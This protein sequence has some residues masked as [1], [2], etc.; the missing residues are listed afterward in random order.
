[1]NS[2]KRQG[3]LILLG[4]LAGVA[5]LALFVATV[6]LWAANQRGAAPDYLG[7]NLEAPWFDGKP[8]PWFLDMFDQPSVKPQESGT[9]QRFPT[10]SVPRSGVEPTIPATAMVEGRLQR[11]VEP[12]NP[13]E[14]TEAS[15]ANGRENYQRFCAACHGADGLADTPVVQLGMPAP[16]IDRLVGLLSE[17]HLYNKIRY[18]G[19]I[20]PGYG[21]QTTQQE[22]WD[23]VNYLKSEQFGEQ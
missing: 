5:V 19:A 15:I 1:M 11:D 12:A 8:W 16:P 10:D 6:A 2:E 7:Y 18:G 17:A 4:V 14:A 13:T 22:R 21:F 20:M 3:R 23:M 9:F